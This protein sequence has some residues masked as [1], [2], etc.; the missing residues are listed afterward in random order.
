MKYKAGDKVRYIDNQHSKLRRK[1]IVGNIYIVKKNH[2]YIL[3]FSEDSI[4]G[5]NK[6]EVTLIGQL[7][8]SF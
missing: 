5:L 1:F 7:R 6:Y 3:E 4:Y 2:D 8:F